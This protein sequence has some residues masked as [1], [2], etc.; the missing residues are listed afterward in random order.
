MNP[1]DTEM[2]EGLRNGIWNLETSV[3]T[4]KSGKRMTVNVGIKPD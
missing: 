2:Y 4:K 1:K 3:A